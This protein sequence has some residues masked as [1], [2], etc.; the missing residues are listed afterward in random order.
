MTKNKPDV[1]MNSTW[2]VKHHRSVTFT[3]GRLTL[4]DGRWVGLDDCLPDGE[5]RE[6]SAKLAA[7]V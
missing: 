5:H 2:Y 3:D 4:R 6:M 7:K 1:W